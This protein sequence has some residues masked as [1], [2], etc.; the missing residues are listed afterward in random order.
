[1]TFDDII[2]FLLRKKTRIFF[3][4]LSQKMAF[5]QFNSPVEVENGTNGTNVGGGN[6][7]KKQF[8]QHIRNIY[9]DPLNRRRN[10]VF[11]E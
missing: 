9:G 1:V 10:I 6:K 2:R 3:N 7:H 8:G 11:S 4:A 5:Q